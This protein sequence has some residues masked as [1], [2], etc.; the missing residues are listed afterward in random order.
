MQVL[1]YTVIKDKEQYD[2]YCQNLEELLEKDKGSLYQ[3]EVD[4]LTL[5]IEDF[6]E[7]H[8]LLNDSDPVQL[9]LSLMRE[10]N[11]KAKD[12]VDLLGVSKGYVS[13]ILHYRKGMSKNVIRQLA[14]FFGVNQGAFNRVYP[15]N[16]VP[17]KDIVKKV[18]KLHS[19]SI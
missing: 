11:Y 18:K 5:L 10:R 4:L 1:K 19:A 14:T 7:K 17:S 6:D 13:D 16:E 9:L 15:V 2:L 8:S 3:D 12:L